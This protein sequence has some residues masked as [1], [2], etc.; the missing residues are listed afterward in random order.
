MTTSKP[1]YSR[2][3]RGQ[4]WRIFKDP[5]ETRERIEN[6]DNHLQE[7]TRTW[8]IVSVDI[9]NDN[10]PILNCVA[11][12]TKMRELPCHVKVT[13]EGFV[14]NVLCEHIMTVNKSDLSNAEFVGVLDEP[15]MQRVEVAL[16]NQLGLSIQVPSLEVLKG[17]IEKLA[18]MKAQEM[19]VREKQVTD[20]V[21][22]DIASKLE[23]IFNLAKTDSD[24]IDSV[25][26]IVEAVTKKEIE[27]P[28]E[29]GAPEETVETPPT[30]VKQNDSRRNKWTE[31]AMRQFMSDFEKFSSEEMQKR[32]GMSMKSLYTTRSRFKGLLG[33]TKQ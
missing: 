9:S 31:E 27:V 24:E 2:Y 18:N 15:S 7:K 12:S 16:A 33:E 17:F 14:C 20:T 3:K 30:P 22:L 25:A 13:M 28:K 6:K 29:E 19:R 11:M 4:I 10:A 23:D 21:V 1:N 32:Y 8:L 26:E 5:K